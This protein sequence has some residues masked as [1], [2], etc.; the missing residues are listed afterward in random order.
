[1][2]YRVLILADLQQINYHN[3]S[4]MKNLESDTKEKRLA[5]SQK[6][7]FVNA[8]GFIKNSLK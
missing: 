8:C 3:I 5:C 1:M 7:I 6:Y 2:F 4:Q